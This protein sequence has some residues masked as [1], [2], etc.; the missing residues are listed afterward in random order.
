[1]DGK[2]DK[3]PILKMIQTQAKKFIIL[4]CSN[5][6]MKYLE[7]YLMKKQMKLKKRLIITRK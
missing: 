5:N 4:N 2:K 3:L 7:V 1:M 6:L